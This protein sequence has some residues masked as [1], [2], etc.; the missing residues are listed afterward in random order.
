MADEEH[1]YDPAE[2]VSHASASFRRSSSKDAGLGFDVFCDSLATEADRQLAMG[3]AKEM[4]NQA[5]DAIRHA[6][7]RYCGDGPA[8]Q[9]YVA[10]WEA[11]EEAAGHV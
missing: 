6:G 3:G 1:V 9:C 11:R 4:L 10:G 5:Y 2:T 8:C 7:D